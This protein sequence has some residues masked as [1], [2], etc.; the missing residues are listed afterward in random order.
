MGG[1]V[2]DGYSIV[3]AILNSKIPVDT[4]VDGLAASIAGVI[5][6]SGR[7]CY[8]TDYGTLM[9]HNP[10]G[11]ED[12]KVLG[13]V[14]DTL[15]TILSNRSKKTADQISAMMSKETWLSAKDALSHGFVDEVISSG[16][17]KVKV[18]KTESLS[19]MALIYN[20]LLN[21]TNNMKINTLLKLS[22]NADESE[23]EKAIVALNEALASK[24][25]E[26]TELKNRLKAIEDEKAEN[27]KKAKE[28]LKNKATEL[29]NRLE[30]EGKI[31]AEE[32]AG[33][34][35]QASASESSFEFVSNMTAKFGN[36]KE[37]KKPFDFKNVNN[38]E[39]RSKWTYED[40]EKKD[41]EGLTNMYKTDRE[42]F[43]ELV[44]TV[45]VK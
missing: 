35:E 41:L 25:T 45:K 26:L 17:K 2:I 43:D 27:E 13:L 40:W 32:K 8:I 33:I 30:K 7:K 14:K 39:D 10:S 1:S 6:V 28:A 11:S 36:G 19:D 16:K 21:P 38:A 24:E 44:K 12:N 5:A 15:V 42:S 20:K 37:S 18:Q 34:I 22:N 4:Y 31:K 29:A 9:L 23:Q 3:S